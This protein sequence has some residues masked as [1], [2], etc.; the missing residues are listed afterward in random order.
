VS[1]SVNPRWLSLV[2]MALL[3]S[4]TPNRAA[5]ESA[6]A[7]VIVKAQFSSRTSLQVSKHSLQFDVVQPAQP[8]TAT[9]RFAAAARTSNGAPVLLT[10]E[11][12]DEIRGMDG[13]HHDGATMT[14]TDADEGMSVELKHGAAIT[15]RRWTGS[16]LR[17]G[18]LVFA[19]R[20]ASVGRYS[21]PIRLTLTAP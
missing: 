12:V 5:A 13:L 4:I 8:A 20:T 17:T 21:V 7:S 14:L 15:A 9:V 18:H 11:M 1:P 6:P 19:L 10:F 16:G 3:C 2:T